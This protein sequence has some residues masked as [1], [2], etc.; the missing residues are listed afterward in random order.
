MDRKPVSDPNLAAQGE[1]E[2]S[3]DRS[4]NFREQAFNHN[5]GR[6]MRVIKLLGY[7]AMM[8]Q[9]GVRFSGAID[10]TKAMRQNFSSSRSMTQMGLPTGPMQAAH[11]LPGQVTVAAREI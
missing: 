5:L 11:F 8:R 4:S 3:I 1:F 6:D 9:N 2:G 10:C 7:V